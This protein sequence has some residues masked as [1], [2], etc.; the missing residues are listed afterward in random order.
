MSKN[1]KEIATFF[2]FYSAVVTIGASVSALSADLGARMIQKD[3]PGYDP[4]VAA[5]T[6]AVGG[7][8]MG[9]I[10]G[11]CIVPY[12]LLGGGK[13]KDVDYSESGWVV[14][15]AI[16]AI[17]SGLLGQAILKGRGKDVL[18]TTGKQ[19]AASAAGAVPATLIL[20]IAVG[21]MACCALAIASSCAKDTKENVDAD[22][23]QKALQ[24][25]AAAKKSGGLKVAKSTGNT[26]GEDSE[27]PS[28]AVAINVGSGLFGGK[29]KSQSYVEATGD[30]ALTGARPGASV[31]EI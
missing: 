2:G 13:R 24:L 21:L 5:A 20:A 30:A 28:D 3:Y 6:G 18:S 27:L 1:V 16:Q 8:A 29:A 7:A 4:E 11:M 9:T 25:M 10:L 22:Q 19:A 15:A 14:A 26:S 12:V 31:T 17:L 23:L